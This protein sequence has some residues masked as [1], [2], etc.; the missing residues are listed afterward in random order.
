MSSLGKT[1]KIFA[2]LN[3]PQA[4]FFVPSRLSKISP[5]KVENL[6]TYFEEGNYLVQDLDSIGWEKFIYDFN[7]DL[8]H[9]DEDT[10]YDVEELIIESIQGYLEEL[11]SI[12]N[13]HNRTLVAELEGDI[14]EILKRIM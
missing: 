10:Y 8:D 12:R 7:I 5:K 4:L 11:D 6:F 9:I 1:D 3:I 2:A 13:D 14:E